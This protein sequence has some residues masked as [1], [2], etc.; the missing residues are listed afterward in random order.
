MKYFPYTLKEE[1]SAWWM[2]LLVASMTTWQEVYDKFME[3]YY[4]P[5]ETA[6][7]RKEIGNFEQLEGEVFHEVWGRFK[8]LIMECPHH[9]FSQ[10]LLN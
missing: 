8:Q 6:R 1:A 2:T 7:L 3:K 10:E 9:S 4:S 5:L